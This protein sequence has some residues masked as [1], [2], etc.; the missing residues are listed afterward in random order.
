MG[1]SLARERRKSTLLRGAGRPLAALPPG[2]RSALDAGGEYRKATLQPIRRQIQGGFRRGATAGG[3]TN[4]GKNQQVA[5]KVASS[6][7]VSSRNSSE[8]V[9]HVRSHVR[10]VAPTLAARWRP[11]RR[12]TP[13]SAD[14]RRPTL[15]VGARTVP[16]S[17]RSHR[18][19]A[20]T[21][22]GCWPRC[23]EVRWR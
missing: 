5:R 9:A 17:S 1:A 4:V 10:V 11:G 23:S 3:P 12:G 18:P 19:E 20:P 13:Q 7:N 2:P 16:A 15:R 6:T 14:H 21:A 22:R 8:T